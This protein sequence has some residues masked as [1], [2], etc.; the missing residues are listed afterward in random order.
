VQEAIAAQSPRCSSLW[1]Y[2]IQTSHNSSTYTRKDKYPKHAHHSCRRRHR[3]QRL[4]CSSYRRLYS[5]HRAANLINDILCSPKVHVIL[6]I[7]HHSLH[8]ASYDKAIAS[9]KPNSWQCSSFNFQYLLVSFR[10]P[11]SCYFFLVLPSLLSFLLSFL[12]QSVLEGS[13]HAR[14]DQ[15]N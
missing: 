11:S 2:G 4:Y 7:L 3:N 5:S 6:N 12:R 15:S 8:T 14:C 13:S 10:S 1:L 9:S